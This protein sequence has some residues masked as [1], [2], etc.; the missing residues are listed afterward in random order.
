V[1]GVLRRFG[2]WQAAIAAAGL[3]AA[4]PR[5]RWDTVAILA[6]VNEWARVH[7]TAPCSTAWVAAAPGHPS[8]AVVRACFGGF[9]AAVEAAGVHAVGDERWTPEQIIDALQTWGYAH[10]RSPH[11][12]E[13]TSAGREHPAYRTVISRLGSWPAALKAAGLT[14]AAPARHREWS[15]PQMIA[16]LRAW[17]R[18]HGRPPRTTDWPTPT[19][20]HPAAQIVSRRFGGWHAAL[21]RA[22]LAFSP[23]PPRWQAGDRSGIVAAI[24][25]WTSTHDV[26]P[27]GQE[28]L[29]ASPEHP[30]ARTVVRVFGSWEPAI[31]AA[32]YRP[33]APGISPLERL[34]RTQRE[35]D[36]A[37]AELSRAQE[38]ARS[39]IGPAKPRTV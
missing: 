24:R 25:A 6:A 29:R 27:I 35:L 30:S 17:N 22:G 33:A 26:V 18:R 31:R 15:E 34:I 11:A 32:G 16:A 8:S 10:G 5:T 4:P 1:R 23:P 38:K 39:S 9:A 14:A 28:W 13:W 36:R 21:E 2:S 7:G 3:P 20:E 37:A 19:S 12:V